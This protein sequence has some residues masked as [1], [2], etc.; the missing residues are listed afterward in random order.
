MTDSLWYNTP[1]TKWGEG[2]PIGNGRIGAVV[3]SDVN[4]ET[5]GLTEIT[6]WSGQSE[7]SPEVYGGREAIKKLQGVYLDGDYDEGKKLEGK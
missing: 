1:A 3:M 4:K 2:V 5:W 7:S 6:F